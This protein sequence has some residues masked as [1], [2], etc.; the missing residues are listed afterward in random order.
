MRNLINASSAIVNATNGVPSGELIIES[1]TAGVPFEVNFGGYNGVANLTNTITLAN[2]NQIEI[3]GTLAPSV[4]TGTY[5]FTLTTYAGVAPSC[6]ATSTIDGS[7]TLKASSTLVLTSAAST[8][9][10][11][12]CVNSAIT[13]ITYTYGGGATSAQVAGQTMVVDGLPTGVTATISNTA[14]TITFDGSPS[15]TTTYTTVYNYTVSSVGPSG[16]PEA[17][18]YGSITV[19]PELSLIHI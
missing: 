5:S 3:S 10:Q 9:S 17:V 4:T 11:T 8:A 15:V 7:I 16:C 2:K 1:K 12:V 14:K 6:V 19:E 13:S 18:L